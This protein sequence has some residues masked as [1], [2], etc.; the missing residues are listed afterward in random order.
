MAMDLKP[1]SSLF[2][3][4]FGTLLRIGESLWEEKFVLYISFG[5]SEDDILS[6]FK[7]KPQIKELS[8]DKMRRMMD[9][10]LKNPDWGYP[11]F[12]EKRIIPRWSVIRVLTSHGILNK[13]V[14]LY[15]ICKLKEE[16]FLERYVI[17]YQEKVPQVLQAYYQGKTVFGD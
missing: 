3:M 4:A 12:L 9:F 5:W 11:S 6:A 14:N 10:F 17:K 1:S 15:T 13:Y 16:K 2:Y 7:K 8:K